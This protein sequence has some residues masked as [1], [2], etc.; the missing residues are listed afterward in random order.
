MQRDT[1][2]ENNIRSVLLATCY[3]LISLIKQKVIEAA[4]SKMCDLPRQ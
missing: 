4:E 2:T 3:Y 1:L